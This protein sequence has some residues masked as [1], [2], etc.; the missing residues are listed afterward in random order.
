M[1]DYVSLGKH[2]WT[3]TKEE[4]HQRTHDRTKNNEKQS[5]SVQINFPS[6]SPGIAHVKRAG[7]EDE[8]MR[9]MK[10]QTDVATRAKSNRLRHVQC[11]EIIKG[12]HR[13]RKFKHV[14][15]LLWGCWLNCLREFSSFYE[16]REAWSKTKSSVPRSAFVR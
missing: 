13:A 9:L 2:S 8:V 4:T 11:V 14:F 10:K 1:N 5:S 12:K 7:R 6:D 3:S 16:G 15:L